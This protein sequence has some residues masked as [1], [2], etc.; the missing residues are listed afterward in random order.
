MA[1]LADAIRTAQLLMPWLPLELATTY[2][3]EWIETADD[4]LAKAAMRN[5]VNYSKHFAGNRRADGTFRYEEA[6]Y[7]AVKEGFRVALMGVG[8][9]PD[10]FQEQFVSLLE[11]E[12]SPNEF[13]RRVDVVAS[14]VLTRSAELKE[15]YSSMYGL[16]MSDA[17]L[18][19]SVLDPSLNDAVLEKRITTAEIG[20]EAALRGYGLDFNMADRLYESGMT[21]QS[22]NEVFSQAA[23]TIPEINALVARHNDPDDTFDL[24]EFLSAAVFGDT[25]QRRRLRQALANEQGSFSAQGTV[26]MDQSGG[27]SGLANR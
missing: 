7:A 15:Y 4:A 26:A 14:R 17:A 24:N 25:T 3:L 23:N 2:A 10:L 19:A 1:T 9:N 20:A 16:E 12:V 22:A 13:R 27:L 6:D 5:D 8:V 21:G 18:V 11:N